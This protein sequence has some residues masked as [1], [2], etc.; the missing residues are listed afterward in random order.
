MTALPAVRLW[1]VILAALGVG[2]IACACEKESVSAQ[3]ELDREP[4]N[5]PTVPAKPSSQPPP[6]PKLASPVPGLR[7]TRR[8]VAGAG[9]VADVFV[10][11]LSRLRLVGIDARTEGRVVAPVEVLRAEA[12]AHVAIN[13]TFF[14]GERRPLGLLIS[15]G[16][17]NNPLR[18]AD[19]GVLTVD[20]HG[21]AALVHTRDFRASD[22]IDFAV[23]C[24]PRVVI[25]AVP[26]GLKPQ[27]ARRTGL[28]I[29]TPTQVALFVVG[30]PVEANTLA[31]WLAEPEANGGLGCGDAL[32]LDGGPSSQLD[33]RGGATHPSLAGGWGV[34]N[35]IGVVNR[36]GG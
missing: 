12:D 19:W 22:A 9:V 13:G 34:P 29:Q 17:T 36:A 7:H 18:T 3:A 15:E 4:P 21:R 23:Q 2:T 24:G 35:A 25:D 31:A 30:A 14:D 20:N 16:V 11:D 28:C 5:P 26:P 1:L 33:T 10:A 32:L 8:V 27:V 6:A